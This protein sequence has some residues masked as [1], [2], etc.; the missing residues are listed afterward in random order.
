MS[1]PELQDYENHISELS[2]NALL[3]VLG[4]PRNLDRLWLYVLNDDRSFIAEPLKIR[5]QG[6]VI[7]HWLHI[8]WKDLAAL[9]HAH[10][11]ACKICICFAHSPSL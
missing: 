9:S 1:L 8:G 3:Y 10:A 2:L 11:F 6:Q 5:L 4:E 7:M